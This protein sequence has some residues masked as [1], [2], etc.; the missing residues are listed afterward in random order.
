MVE[1]VLEVGL[2]VA[3]P[4][5][6]EAVKPLMTAAAEADSSQRLSQKVTFRKV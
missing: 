3:R 6:D 2:L 4:V 5:E 1:L